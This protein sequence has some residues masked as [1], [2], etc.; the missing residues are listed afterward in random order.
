MVDTYLAT[1]VFTGVVNDGINI[2]VPERF[3]IYPDWFLKDIKIA[4][5]IKIIFIDA[6]GKLA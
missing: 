4:K 3:S 6:L 5:E 2:F 1:E